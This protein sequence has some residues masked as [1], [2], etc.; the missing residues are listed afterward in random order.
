[1]A[2]HVPLP[3]RLAMHSANCELN[4]LLCVMASARAGY[5]IEELTQVGCDASGCE[6]TAR[7]QACRSCFHSPVR[8]PSHTFIHR[9]SNAHSILMTIICW[10]PGSGYGRS[11]AAAADQANLLRSGHPTDQAAQR[12]L[13]RDAWQGGLAVNCESTVQCVVASMFEQTPCN[14]NT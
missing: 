9:T 12:I 6:C 4:K 13:P 10:Q 14:L 1:M 7:R 11:D 8:A 2:D 5:H 3:T